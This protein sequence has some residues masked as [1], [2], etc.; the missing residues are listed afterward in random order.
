MLFDYDDNNEQSILNYAKRLEG[1]TFQEICDAYE[2]S[3]VKQYQNHQSFGIREEQ[4]VY[5]TNS[6]AKGQLGNILEQ[7][8]FGY[9]PNSNQEADFPKVGIELKLTCID[10]KKDGNYRAG[11]RLSITNISYTE[12]VIDDFYQSHVWN[13]IHR[14]LLI[15]YFR[16]KTIN[17]MDY[18]IRFV[19]LFTPPKEDLKII[20]EDYNSIN[21]K[22][23]EGLAHELSESDT[24]YLGAC[25]KGA[26]RE[27]G[28]VP[29]YYGQHI[30]AMKRNYCFK[31]SYMN[32]VLKT[33]ILHNEVPYESILGDITDTQLTFEQF[34]M[35]KIDRHVGKTDE[36]LCK[37]FDR[38]YNKNKAQWNDLAFRMLGIKGNHAEEFV[39]A[40]VSVKTIRIEEN[41]QIREHWPL[42]TFKYKEFV[43]EEWEDSQVHN[44]L[45]E[46]RF[47]FVVFKN[48]G[49]SYTLQSCQMWNMPYNDLNTIVYQGWKEIQNIVKHGIVFNVE[50]NG[51]VSNNLP[52]PKDNQIIH[53]RPHAAHAAYKLNNGFVKGDIKKDGDELPNGEWMTKQSFW[54]NKSY[55]LSQLKLREI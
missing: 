24:Y 5:Y 47:L 13:K 4:A 37:E 50:N 44:I 33:Y 17:R 52:K 34:I 48:N 23:K 30:P 15:H 16:D 46:T 32:Y 14:I 1:K 36:E 25:T 41:G 27:K 18:Q 20:I 10:R 28:T 38:P 8:Y 39:K 3:P 21:N 54:I 9:K 40:N 49:T 6:K 42:P 45:D 19:N 7:N 55:L 53:V 22:I 12:P 11:E 29:Q 2:E 26:N 43:N 35:S 31:T 51:S